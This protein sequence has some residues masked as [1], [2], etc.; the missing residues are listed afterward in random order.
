M[1]EVPADYLSLAANQLEIGFSKTEVVFSHASGFI[2]FYKNKYYLITN[3]HNVTGRNPIERSR[4]TREH[5]GIPDNIKTFFRFDNNSLNGPYVRIM[6][7]EDE[8]LKV[9]KWLVHPKFKERVD[10]VAIQIN[11]VK[12][13]IFRPINQG[14][15]DNNIPPIVGDECFVIGYPF[16]QSRF[17]GM[18]IWKKASIATEPIL[19][20]E[21]L[22]KILID[23]ATRPGLSGS[24]VIYQRT[25][26][27]NVYHGKFNKDSMIG[28]IRGFL[29]IYSGRIGKDEFQAQL[30]IVWKAKVIE[31]IIDGNM[32][33]NTEFQNW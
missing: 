29:G 28:R 6:L 24:P 17:L 26:I 21:H 30:G 14:D 7:Y 20:E 11:P 9:P 15:F 16:S 3:W 13:I 27:H 4:I 32:R 5:A 8:E 2:Y 1:I 12:G 22:P 10:V 33:G 23:T 18:P 19:D 25:G 31:E